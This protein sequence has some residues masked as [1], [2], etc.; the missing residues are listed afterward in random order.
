MDGTRRTFTGTRLDARR[1]IGGWE[2]DAGTQI[3]DTEEEE[4]EEEA[5]GEDEERQQE[6]KKNRRCNNTNY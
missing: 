6:W 3:T 1:V 5:D 2:R 4:E